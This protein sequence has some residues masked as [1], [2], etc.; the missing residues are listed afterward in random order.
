[1][2]LKKIWGKLVFETLKNRKSD[3]LNSKT[4]FCSRL[5]G[6]LVNNYLFT[7]I[8]SSSS[9]IP[10]RVHNILI[11]YFYKSQKPIVK[12]SEKLKV[13]VITYV[14][15]IYEEKYWSILWEPLCPRHA[16]IHTCADY[17]NSVV[18][19]AHFFYLKSKEVSTKILGK[20]LEE[21]F[22]ISLQIFSFWKSY[23]LSFYLSISPK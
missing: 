11:P 2:F 9:S 21:T 15:L 7:F 23:A 6:N 10:P 3:F 14:L 8:L 20:L 1:M 4:C 19:L 18:Q 12:R 22:R 17:A 13:K 5:Y 16:N